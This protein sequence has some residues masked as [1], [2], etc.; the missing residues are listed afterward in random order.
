MSADPEVRVRYCRCCASEISSIGFKRKLF[1]DHWCR[2]RAGTWVRRTGRPTSDLRELL[3]ERRC[4]ICG[5]PMQ[6]EIPTHGLYCSD[7]CKREALRRHRRRK[8]L[9][10]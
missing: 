3:L 5:G 7:E 8:K 4:A 10:A 9:A 2:N 6:T 1:C